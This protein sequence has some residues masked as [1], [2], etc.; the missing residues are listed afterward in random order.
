MCITSFIASGYATQDNTPQYFITLNNY[1][2][3]STPA[4][5]K[6]T[7]ELQLFPNPISASTSLLQLSYPLKNASVQIINSSG[8]SVSSN[9]Y[10]TLASIDL[11]G[12]PAGVYW[13]RLQT[14]NGS[15]HKKIIKF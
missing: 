9:H 1:L 12:F 3:T 2:I 14:E 6:E 11:T 13:L 15:I 10:E 8:L 5:K 4:I 7:L